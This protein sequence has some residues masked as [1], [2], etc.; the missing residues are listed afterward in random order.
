MKIASIFWQVLRGAKQNFLPVLLC[1]TL[2]ATAANAETIAQ[3]TQSNEI[4]TTNNF[5][6]SATF[7]RMWI[8]YNVTEGGVKGMRIHTGF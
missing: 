7:Q 5:K 3:G 1:L 4:S 2:L 8:D 6:P